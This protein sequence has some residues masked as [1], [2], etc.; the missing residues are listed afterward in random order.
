MMI[1]FDQYLIPVLGDAD[2]R[3]FS[4]VPRTDSH[5]GVPE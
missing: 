3:G 1:R 5:V 4:S 2:M